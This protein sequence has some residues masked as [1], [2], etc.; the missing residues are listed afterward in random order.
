MTRSLKEQLKEWV[1][2]FKRNEKEAVQE[3]AA[4]ELIEQA[5]VETVEEARIKEHNSQQLKALAVFI[6]GYNSRLQN[7][8]YEITGKYS[9]QWNIGGWNREIMIYRLPNGMI[10]AV[11][12]KHGIVT[13][14]PS[15][16]LE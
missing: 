7:P 2:V 15:G 14:N 13:F 16:M 6:K 4:E 8:N 12:N 1:K 9:P 3:I 5:T 10:I 11:R